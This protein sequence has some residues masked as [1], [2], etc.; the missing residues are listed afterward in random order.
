MGDESPNGQGSQHHHG[1]TIREFRLARGMTQLELAERWPSGPVTRRYIQKVEA[2]DSHVLDQRTL[3]ALAELLSVP[4]WRFGLSEYDPF[5]P[6]QLAARGERMHDEILDV[7]ELL[8]DRTWFMRRTAPVP[9]TEKN[10]NRLVELFAGLVVSLPP[11]AHLEQRFLQLYAQVQRLHAV[12]LIERQ[13][14]GSA[15]LAFHEMLR[16]AERLGEPAAIALALMG[17]GTELERAGRQRE[18]VDRLEQARDASFGAS[19]QV[20]ALVNAYLAR[21]YASAKE[22]L[23]FQRAI[24][25]AQTIAT[26]LGAAYGDGQDYVFHRLSGILAERSYGYL[27]IGEPK[28]V[29]AMRE[30]I[31]AQIDVTHNTWLHA[32]IPLD[33]ARAYLMLG[34]V[35]ESV[36][37][38]REFYHRTLRLESP[39]AISRAREHLAE[40]EASGYADV[41]VVRAFREELRADM[42]QSTDEKVSATRQREI[43]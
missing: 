21:A 2:G 23:R 28:K 31:A 19:R 18:A 15:L 30:E 8:V 20:A 11:T 29:L 22:P 42:H 16:V 39:H 27:E 38:G 3:R 41:A 24:D 32:W 25:T 14:Y 5:N 40:L 1:L 33:W 35:E 10:T 12:M 34:E 26:N 6:I 7:V 17:I 37:E 43:G 9:E 4:L 13:H 36:R